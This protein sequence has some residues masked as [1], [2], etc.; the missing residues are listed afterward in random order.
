VRNAISSLVAAILFT[1]CVVV[2]TPPPDGGNH[3]P[4]APQPSVKPDGDKPA[5]TSDAGPR[6]T[7]VPSAT[8]TAAPSATP[9]VAPTAEP[10]AP[11]AQACGSRGMAQCPKDQFCD[12][13]K[14]SQC[15]ATDRGGTCQTIPQMCTKE[16][17][18]VCGCDGQT[19]PNP[20]AAHAKGQSIN[21]YAK[22]N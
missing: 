16:F 6:P 8:P 2:A 15:G 17:R 12:F 18:Q 7:S 21:T 13:P 11:V 10:A 20:C 19:Y 9:T 3:H 22:C 5:A 1:G 4:P 14:G